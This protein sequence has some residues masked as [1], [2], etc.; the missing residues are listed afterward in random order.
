MKALSN[1]FEQVE[2]MLVGVFEIFAFSTSTIAVASDG[3]F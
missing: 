1:I 3:G 2:D